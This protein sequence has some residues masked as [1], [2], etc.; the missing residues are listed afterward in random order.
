MFTAAV[1][2]FQQDMGCTMTGI[3]E[4]WGRTWQELLAA[5]VG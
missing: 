2:H 1:L 3:M 5:E 4:E